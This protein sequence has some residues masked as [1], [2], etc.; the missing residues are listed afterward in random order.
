MTNPGKR[1]TRRRGNPCTSPAP[2]ARAWSFA[3]SAARRAAA[4]PSDATPERSCPTNQKATGSLARLRS[5]V[6]AAS[7]LAIAGRTRPARPTSPSRRG[8]RRSP[9][10]ARPGPPLQQRIQGWLVRAPGPQTA[11][12]RRP[13]RWRRRDHPPSVARCPKLTMAQRLELIPSRG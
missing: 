1:G 10:R 11:S 12:S 7:R 8:P 9:F 3:A 6:P 5:P 4:G 13:R 2:V